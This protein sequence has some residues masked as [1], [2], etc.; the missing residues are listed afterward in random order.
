MNTTI[1]MAQLQKYLSN[2]FTKSRVFMLKNKTQTPSMIKVTEQGNPTGGAL[3]YPNS[4]SLPA[5]AV[6]FCPIKKTPRIIR[7]VLGE[8]SIYKD[9]QAKETDVPLKVQR[10]EFIKGMINVRPEET[11]L[12][13]F[14]LLYPGNE[15][16]PVR[17]T[18]KSIIFFE[19]RPEVDVED[20]MKQDEL[21][22]EA[23]DWCK[24]ANWDELRLHATVL[25]VDTNQTPKEVR[26]HIMKKYA[27]PNPAKFLQGLK[28]K[29][30]IRKYAILEAIKNGVLSVNAATN[31][32]SWTNGNAICM[33]PVG[34]DPVS[35]LTDQTFSD[36][37]GEELFQHIKS[38]LST[39]IVGAPKEPEAKFKIQMPEDTE[40]NMITE[41][42]EAGIVEDKVSWLFYKT[43]TP[44][45][46]KWN[47]KKALVKELIENKEFREELTKEIASHK[48]PI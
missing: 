9:E 1:E 15:T 41:A 13:N 3:R 4:W 40:I 27:E 21:L 10:V 32:I 20:L 22:T 29:T 26:W 48:I 8:S 25:G 43:G 37:R 7:Y 42:I 28:D 33:A 16:N 18:T 46:K 11:T 44:N 5:E 14:M 6:I 45:A 19:Y 35:H 47:G 30:N 2:D 23:K 24:N 36:T 38:K 17:D 34:I 12:M 31:T 39:E